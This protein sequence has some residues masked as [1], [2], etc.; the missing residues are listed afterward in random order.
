[1]CGSNFAE[2]FDVLIVGA[3]HAGCE[4][5]AAAARMGLRTALFTLNLDLIAQMSCNP[6]IGGVAK[7]HLV[8]E[9][10]ALGGIMGEVADSCG[11]QFRLLNTSR[12]PAVWSPRA[13]CDKA[14]YRSKMR[15]KLESIANLFIKQAEVVDLIREEGLQPGTAR[16]TGVVLRD[17]RRVAA[18]ATVVTTGTF[19]NGLIHCGEQTYSAGR[20]GEAASI[21]L[22]ENL[23]K[24][25]L[26]ETRLK[27]GTPPRLDGRTIDWSRFREQP[28]DTD[29]TPFSFRSLAALES[30][31]VNSTDDSGKPGSRPAKPAAVRWQPP[32]RQICCHIAGTTPETL[33]LIRAN[34]HR[35]PM[36]TGQISGIGPRYCPSIEDKVVRFP[37]KASHQF[38][39]EPEGL[40]TREIYINGMSTSLP[41]DV[42]Q[43]MVHSIPGLENAEMLRPGYAIEYDAIDPTE[44]D[45]TLQVKRLRGLYLAG[46]I[47]GTSGYEEAAC[48]GLIAGI[49]AALLARRAQQN[50][51]PNEE[52]AAEET[53]ASFTL[54]RTEAY[55]GIL[56][57]DLIS[58]GTDEPYRMFTSRAEFRL[59]LRIDNA[60]ARLTPHGRRLG[61]IDDVAWEAF[62]AKQ[63][64]AAALQRVLETTRLTG[65]GLSIVTAA[66]QVN[67]RSE[68][69]TTADVGLL[70]AGELYAQL[71]KRPS[72]TVETVLPALLPDLE[73]QRET[74]PEFVPWLA[75]L[76]AAEYGQGGTLPVWVRNEMKTVETAIKFAGYLAQQQRAIQRLRDDEA[77]TIPTWFNY[78]ACSG[79][80]REMVEKLDRVRPLTL[81]QASRIA[82]VTPAAVALIQC[83]LEIQSRTTQSLPEAG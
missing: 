19:L 32:L 23:K 11:I 20:S 76:A 6:A 44:L 47:N 63:A 45:R 33:E 46:Q 34:V 77:R 2:K 28:G 24:L 68:V 37:D 53:S 70:T 52:D 57:D 36:Y 30:E 51:W 78:R 21:L 67:T 40:N 4:A 74:R 60:D 65:A 17:G 81:G 83:F 58:K 39:L 16:I 12:G 41:M 29:P 72:I 26:R 48:Q 56:I 38:F 50:S 9:I 5:A 55:T 82:G 42:Q 61:L 79:L 71:L 18:H 22:G 69:R 8:R 7:G 75:A 1:M 31:I 13:Q 25:G 54:D 15:E 80:S 59:H 64:R 10:D 49:N 73:S 3:G 62:Q 27:T 14:L 66:L 35:S 43:A